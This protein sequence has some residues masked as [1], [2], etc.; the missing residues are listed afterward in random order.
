MC[1][2]GIIEVSLQIILFLMYKHKDCLEI[3]K[4]SFI[5]Y[6]I[7]SRQHRRPFLPLNTRGAL[8]HR[9]GPAAAVQNEPV[10]TRRSTCTNCVRW[11]TSSGRFAERKSDAWA[12]A[13]GGSWCDV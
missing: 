11:S 2:D 13:G 7:T 8:Q 12:V 10:C 4:R 6:P 5:G 3:C 9:T 1:E